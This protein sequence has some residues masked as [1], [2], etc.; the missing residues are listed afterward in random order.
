MRARRHAA[1]AICAVLAAALAATAG[2]GFRPLYGSSSASNAAE[3]SSVQI[4]IIKDRSGQILRNFLLDRLTPRGAPS[5]ARYT[6]NVELIE[7]KSDIAVRTDESA[8]RSTLTIYAD[9]KLTSNAGPEKGV[10]SGRVISV[11]SY[12]RLS[13][14]YGTLASEQNARQRS[15]REIAEE[16]RLRIASAIRTPGAFVRPAKPTEGSAAGATQ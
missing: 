15:L 5:N 6:L 14:D 10:H 12:N 1:P 2:C 8:T 9:Y 3:L 13:S 7:S 11:S 4:N 16:L